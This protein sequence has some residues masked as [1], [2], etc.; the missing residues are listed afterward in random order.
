MPGYQ[1]PW[2]VTNN[3]TGLD[4]EFLS[5]SINSGRSTY[6]DVYNGGGFT[7]TINNNLN[8][9]G[10]IQM[11]DS[12]RVR[13]TGSGFDVG[14]WVDEIQ[15]QD[16][17]GDT[18]LST[19]TIVCS[20][21]IV[22]LGRRLVTNLAL[23]SAFSGQQAL[24]FNDVTQ[25]PGIT[26]AGDGQS[27]VSATTYTGAPMQRLN[28]LINTERGV[29]RCRGYELFYV[30][31]ANINQNFFV[32]FNGF[33]RFKSASVIGYEQ[34]SR[35]GLGLNFMNQVAV[36]PTGGGEQLA[37]NTA[38][39]T[40]YGSNYYSLQSEDSTNTQALGLAQWLSNAQSDP[41]VE[42]YEV[43]FSDRAQNQTPVERL[44]TTFMT[45][46]LYQLDYLI[47]NDVVVLNTRTVMEGYSINITASETRVR[48]SMSPFSYYD[49]F[50]LDSTIQGILNYSRLGW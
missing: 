44:L 8:E 46:Y 14:Y 13:A 36:T 3:R 40:A 43:E 39:V 37:T 16:Y 17:P 26:V 31:R 30:P 33:S 32:T 23:P 34:F 21:A 10:S 7:F 6:M 24:F 47:P 9:A 11:G 12:I 2:R 42:R 49:L 4:I 18:G 48:V 41:T 50:T 38:S 25:S 27:L 35:T 19:A 15:C 22:R 29:I 20:D 5:G 45:S 1:I 28:Q